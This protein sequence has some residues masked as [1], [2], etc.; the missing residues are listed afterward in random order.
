MYLVFFKDSMDRQEVLL[1]IL[2]CFILGKG[3]NV[4]LEGKTVVVSGVGQG[5]GGEIARLCV[6]DGASVYLGARTE[7]TL[8]SIAKDLD[9]AGERVGWLATDITDPAQCSA[10]ASAAAKRFGGVDALVQVAALDR[11]FGGFGHTQADDW[12]NTYEVNVVGTTQ[13]AEAVVPRMEGSCGRVG[14]SE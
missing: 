10:L 5:L 4:I 1:Q 6:R 14:R 9:P 3:A 11:V 12:R 8:Q 2:T 13:L 7:A